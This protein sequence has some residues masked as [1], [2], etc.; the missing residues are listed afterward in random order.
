VGLEDST[1]PYEVQKRQEDGSGWNLALPSKIF[2]A[3]EEIKLKY[4][5]TNT[6]DWEFG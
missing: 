1:A 5:E 6:A 4:Y 2:A 3:R